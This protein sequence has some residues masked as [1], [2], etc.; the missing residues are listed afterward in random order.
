VLKENRAMLALFLVAWCVSCI[1]VPYPKYFALQHVPTVVAVVALVIIDRRFGLDRLSFGLI[2]TF[3]LLHLVGAR[4]LYSFAPYDDWAQALLGVRISDQFGFERNH[5][6]RLVHFAFG[7][8]FVYP[9]WRFVETQAKLS[10]FWSAVAAMCIVLA[11]SAVYEI[12]EWLM[13]VAFA[14]DWAESYNGQQGDLWDAQKDMA[15][16]A[17][18]GL[19]SIAWM[20]IARYVRE[21]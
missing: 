7:L 12:A 2:I 20:T 19:V 16:A 11:A 1:A 15:L 8:L 18:G 9:L 13:A 14:P 6:D 21:R 17:G 10:G 5:Y 3:L 4:Y